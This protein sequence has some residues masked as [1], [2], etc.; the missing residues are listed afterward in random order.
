MVNYLDELQ[1]IATEDVRF[2]KEREKTYQGSWCAAGGRSAWFMLRRKIDRI[3][4]MM[5]RPEPPK[6]PGFDLNNLISKSQIDEE[7]LDYLYKSY[8]SEDIF[9]KIEENPSGRDSTVLAEVRDLRRYLLLV[10]S[11]MVATKVVSNKKWEKDDESLHANYMHK[12]V[13]RLNTKIP[14][15]KLV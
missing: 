12:Y 3:L 7:V 14:S 15:T 6:I 11:Y 10:E 5:Q 4:N 8:F 9:R 13:D 2:L 1:G